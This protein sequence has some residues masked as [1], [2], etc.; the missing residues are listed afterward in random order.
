[1]DMR[2][3]QTLLMGLLAVTLSGC[4]VFDRLVYK[5]DIP[6]GNY[7]EQDQID[8]LR[9]Q[10]T[11]EQVQYIMG[12]PM[13]RD[14]FDTSTWYYMYDLKPGKDPRVRRELVL[15]FDDTERLLSMEG[16]YERPANFAVPLE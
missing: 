10:M 14:T 4:S 11:K 3:K 8:K 9:V 2:I 6:Q 1:M 16:D 13:M 12:T 15:K 7:V 5:I